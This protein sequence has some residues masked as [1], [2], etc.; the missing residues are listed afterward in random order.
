MVLNVA[1]PVHFYEAHLR[2]KDLSRV[3]VRDDGC[4]R[5]CCCCVERGKKEEVGLSV[6][7]ALCKEKTTDS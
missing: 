7:G 1:H 6:T 2:A 3:E 5:A 4:A